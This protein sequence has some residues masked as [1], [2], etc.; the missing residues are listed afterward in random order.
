MRR[1]QTLRSRTMQV[2]AVLAV[3]A[4]CTGSALDVGSSQGA[5]P[6]S[7][8]DGQSPPVSDASDATTDAMLP[9]VGMTVDDEACDITTEEMS[10]QDWPAWGV[11]IVGR[12]PSWKGDVSLALTTNAGVL[13]PQLCSVITY[14]TLSTWTPDGNPIDSGQHSSFTANAFRGNCEI[15]SGPTTEVPSKGLALTATV[16][17]A[18]GSHRVSYRSQKAQ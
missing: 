5:P 3:L 13:Y 1:L 11:R 17:S 18:S 2:A 15:L 10:G 16:E 7:D 8:S 12:C 14:V 6:S 9:P 4:A